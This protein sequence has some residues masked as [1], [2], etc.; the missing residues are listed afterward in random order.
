MAVVR[1][2]ITHVVVELASGKRICHHNRKRHSV[3]AGNKCLAV[4]EHAGGRKNYCRPCAMD[5]LAKAREK[6]LAL[7][8]QVQS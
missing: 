8:Q 4:Y 3:I 5:I 6:L 1:D 2:V 7:E